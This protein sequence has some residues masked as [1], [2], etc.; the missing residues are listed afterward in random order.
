VQNV[1]NGSPELEAYF[2]RFSKT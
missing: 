2:V 1:L